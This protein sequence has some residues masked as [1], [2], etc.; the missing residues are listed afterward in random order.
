[1]KPTSALMPS[2]VLPD[3]PVGSYAEH[4]AERGEP[5][6]YGRDEVRNVVSLAAELGPEE[7]LDRIE[8]AD[9]R[10]RGG[11]WFPTATKWRT[12]RSFASIEGSTMLVVNA[13]EG[14][15][16]SFK[17]R[18]L[19]R[20]DPYSV[21]EGATVAAGVIG[22]T[23]V[24]VAIK[25]SFET[26][27]TRLK[28]AIA[29]MS[30]ADPAALPRFEFVTGPDRYL[31]GEESALL[32]VV[33]GRPPFPRVAPPWRHGALDLDG[34]GEAASTAMAS[35]SDESD[36]PPPALV[37]NVETLARA[38]HVLRDVEGSTAATDTFLATITGDVQHARVAEF[39]IG[40]SLRDVLGADA[41]SAG[42]VLNGVTYPLTG[43][44]E[45][46]KPLLP[47]GSE[48][49]ESL[50][51]GAA[52]FQVFADDVDPRAVAAA[53]AHFLSVESCGQCEPC[54]TDGLA[55]SDILSVTPPARDAVVVAD[56]LT[57]RAARV[58]VGARCGL[59]G[60]Q[61]DVV[62]GL[63]ASFPES[64]VASPP[65]TRPSV[66]IAPLRDLADGQA[67]VDRTYGEIQPDW[68]RDNIWSGQFPAAAEDIPQ[69]TP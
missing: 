12:T 20:F 21:I 59:A 14:E 26:E 67:V 58:T 10:G 48:K 54:K 2:F 66:A 27:I 69:E 61:R 28:S 30:A 16:G 49:G 18:Q 62:E 9:L 11:A 44:D 43:P 51:I 39:P 64:L 36:L 1:M 68:T 8:A 37:Q 42:S 22:A 15:P 50:P 38:A 47:P 6:G 52:A 63:L 57:V 35:D 60:Q 32:E 19:L 65:L 31:F 45:F 4:L 29:E 40:V 7:V 5:G 25:A 24:V 3:A 17:D 46:D 13:A 34:R 33:S 41:D 23:T 55:I 56:E 53:A